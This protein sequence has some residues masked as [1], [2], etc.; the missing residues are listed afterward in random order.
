MKKL[1]YLVLFASVLYAASACKKDKLLTYDIQDNIY[2]NLLMQVTVQVDSVDVS[3]AYSPDSVKDSTIMVPVAVTGVASAVDR[4]FSITVDPASTET[5]ANHYVLPSTFVI[6]AGK[7]VD[8]MPVKL[9]RAAD[10]QDTTETLI[11]N[12]NPNSNF[13]T[14]IKSFIS[15]DTIN[16]LK[17]TFYVSDQLTAGPFWVSICT[18]YFGAFSVK[19]VRLMNTVT[20][21]PLNFPAHG[22]IYDLNGSAEATTYAIT[23]SRYL[24][25]QAAAGT[26]V[27][28][29]DG[30]T[31]MTM[32]ASFQ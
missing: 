18:T 27:Y 13:N 3:F 16:A 8:S 6:P 15:S 23:M 32:G 1:I 21:M 17:M 26:P 14:G 2:F 24:Q 22:I 4:A 28:E 31:L 30:V 25:D 19:K 9:L 29:A 7:L 12:L 5:A 20:G 10:L 11:L